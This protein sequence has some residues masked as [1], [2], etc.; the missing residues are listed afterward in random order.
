MRSFVT[1]NLDPLAQAFEVPAETIM[2]ALESVP[3]DTALAER[4]L[5]TILTAEKRLKLGKKEGRASSAQASANVLASTAIWEG[6][7]AHLDMLSLLASV[8]TRRQDMLVFITEEFTVSVYMAPLLTSPGL[9]G[10]ATI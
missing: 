7:K 4:M 5:E 10:C 9:P 2:G 3:D 6:D 1:D 8:L